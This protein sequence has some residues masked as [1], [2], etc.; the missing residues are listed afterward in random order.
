MSDNSFWGAGGAEQ[1]QA[2]SDR[3]YEYV[4]VTR[5]MEKPFPSAPSGQHKPLMQTIWFPALIAGSIGLLCNGIAHLI[6][7]IYNLSI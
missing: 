7:W 2:E 6:D 5:D 4:V 1:W 3:Y